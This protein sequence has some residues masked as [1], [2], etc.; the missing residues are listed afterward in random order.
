MPSRRRRGPAAAIPSAD[1][2][3][4]S[5]IRLP[6]AATAAATAVSVAAATQ[7]QPNRHRNISNRRQHI[8][9][10][11]A[12][13]AAA[14]QPGTPRCRPSDLASMSVPALR[15]P[16]ARRAFGSCLLHRPWS[17]R[18]RNSARAGRRRCPGESSSAAA[19][20]R[21][22]LCSSRLK[23]SAFR[24]TQNKAKKDGSSFPGREPLRRRASGFVRE[25]HSAG[26]HNQ[27]RTTSRSARFHSKCPLGP[28]ESKELTGL[29]NTKLKVYELPDWQ[30]L[31]SAFSLLRRSNRHR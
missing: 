15:W 4:S 19:A 22:V 25:R 12:V 20:V 2:I 21:V 27:D 31:D 3:R 30:N 29:L 1:N 26:A 18:R 11:A 23:S 6:S 5:R 24:L 10:A 14:Y 9:H 13:S 16:S 17:T 7:Y 8:S 28:Y